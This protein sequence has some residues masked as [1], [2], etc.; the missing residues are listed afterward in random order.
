MRKF[1]FR[2]ERFLQLRRYD[3]RTWE[4]KLA[5]A[6]GKCVKLRQDIEDRRLDIARTILE[7]PG[8][9]SGILDLDIYQAGE[10]YMERLGLEID[11][12][13]LEL[14]AQELKRGEIQKGYLEAS[15]KRKVL[16][17]LKER[18]EADHKKQWL[19]EDFKTLD[20]INTSRFGQ[21]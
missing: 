19:R 6:T 2:L 18:Q 21:I 7:R 12:L 5:E 16:D 4:L 20:D 3:E 10:M 1:R 8:R 13:G 11:G 9:G 14:E 17:K 15:K